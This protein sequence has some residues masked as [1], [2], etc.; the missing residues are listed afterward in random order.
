MWVTPP[1]TKRGFSLWI[2]ELKF[3]TLESELECKTWALVVVKVWGMLLVRKTPLPPPTV[4]DPSEYPGHHLPF[5][6]RYI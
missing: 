2:L 4:L 5:S 3:R 1:H 6:A